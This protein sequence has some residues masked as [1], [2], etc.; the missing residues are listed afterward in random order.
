[1]G[2]H[3][4][5]KITLTTSL[6]VATMATFG[7]REQ[8]HSPIEKILSNDHLSGDDRGSQDSSLEIAR[9]TSVELSDEVV[10]NVCQLAQGRFLTNGKCSSEKLIQCSLDN[11]GIPVYGAVM[12]SHADAAKSLYKILCVQNVVTTKYQIDHILCMS[13]P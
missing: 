11:R 1:M 5:T 8:S 9:P 10:I 12:C 2:S 4:L 7:C 13:R 3:V 6:W